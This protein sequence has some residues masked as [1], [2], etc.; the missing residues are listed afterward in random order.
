[1]TASVEIVALGGLAEFGRN[2]LWMRCGESNIWW[3]SVSP[4]PMRL[5]RA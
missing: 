2:L 4:F 3:T 5:F 1:M